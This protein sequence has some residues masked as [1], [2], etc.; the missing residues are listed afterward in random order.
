[1]TITIRSVFEDDKLYAQAF[2]DDTLYKLNP[3]IYIILDK[4]EEIKAI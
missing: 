1:M 3:Y 2:L 4:L